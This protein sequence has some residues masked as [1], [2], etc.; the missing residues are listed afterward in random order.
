M[1]IWKFCIFFMAAMFCGFRSHVWWI[2][3]FRAKRLYNIQK[4]MH[5]CGWDYVGY[6]HRFKKNIL[7][8]QIKPDGTRKGH[9]MNSI[10]SR[11]GWLQ[12]LPAFDILDYSFK[13]WLQLVVRYKYVSNF[14]IYS[15]TDPIFRQIFKIMRW[16]YNILSP[17][18][19]FLTSKIF[20]C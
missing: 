18:A 11:N 5:N 19:I 20:F 7:P 10:Y 12:Y 14:A 3:C 16:Q 1:R 17:S 13:R 9:D 2:C 8:F 15:S 6:L 4:S